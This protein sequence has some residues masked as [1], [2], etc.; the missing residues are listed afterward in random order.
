MNQIAPDTFDKKEREIINLM[1]V[2]KVE[3]DTPAEATEEKK[4]GLTLDAE[5]LTA[6]VATLFRKAQTEKDYCN[7]YARLCQNLTK[8]ELERLGHQKMTKTVITK[9]ELRKSL[10]QNC[11]NSFDRFFISEEDFQAK[12]NEA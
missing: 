12:D 4:S 3:N 2:D 7:M 1:F 5:N 11:R 9:S 10:L 6:I 8:E